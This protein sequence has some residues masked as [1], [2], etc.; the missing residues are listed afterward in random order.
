MQISA[1][2]THALVVGMEQCTAPDWPGLDGPAYDA[3]R[4]VDWLR[5]CGVPASQISLFLSPIARPNTVL[6][7]DR[8]VVAVEG[9]ANSNSIHDLLSRTYLSLPDVDLLFVFW[10][11]HGLS[12]SKGN[13]ALLYA[14]AIEKDPRAFSVDSFM[15]SLRSTNYEHIANCILVADA[16]ATL[17]ENLDL[18]STI[19]PQAFSVGSVLRDVPQFSMFASQ[20]G[21]VALNDNIARQGLFT[22]ELLKA[23]DD[24]AFPPNMLK[25]AQRLKDRFEELKKS[26]D[27]V[28]LPVTLVSGDWK[29][30]H[31]I[32][33]RG[34]LP[35]IA[36]A[37]RSIPKAYD[38]DKQDLAF[39]KEF[40]LALS[41]GRAIQTF[42]VYGQEYEQHSSFVDRVTDLRVGEEMKNL[43]TDKPT[44][45]CF[46]SIPEVVIRAKGTTAE[47]KELL[48]EGLRQ[49]TGISTE[50]ANGW[51]LIRQAGRTRYGALLFRHL[52]RVEDTSSN[53]MEMIQWYVEDFWK[54]SG[55]LPG[56]YPTVIL[57]VMV[58]FSDKV[59]RRNLLQPST[60]IS[61]LK[62]TMQRKLQDGLQR[63]P[64]QK[65]LDEL[66]PLDSSDVKTW[67]R[68]YANKSGKYRADIDRENAAEALFN[69]AQ[70]R[71]GQT[72]VR[73][74]DAIEK[75]LLITYEELNDDTRIHRNV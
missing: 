16:C 69:G 65:V 75:G 70:C 58:E 38:R 18:K 50:P 49:Q 55:E 5:K 1:Q 66:K 59:F 46:D 60:W 30:D 23:L 42:I 68:R 52:V 37:G 2:K 61:N 33:E 22:S 40:R 21:E 28:Q 10:A 44:D 14:D 64:N 25:I 32:F 3:C 9:G 34:K 11:G 29:T 73:R 13:R 63:K 17:S 43:N 24:E 72:E 41:G 20:Q 45:Q 67:F 31:V 74:T 36:L 15:E 39:V 35:A 4:I 54:E 12:N 51:D 47:L 62:E 6:P 71:A 8:S 19:A 56:T 48:R 53:W 27:I 26:D 7:K 57:F